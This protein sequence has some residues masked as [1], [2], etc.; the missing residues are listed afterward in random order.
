ME[1][2]LPDH[3]LEI[4]A[5]CTDEARARLRVT[6]RTF[7]R[8][9]PRFAPLAAWTRAHGPD[10]Q[11]T[12]L[13]DGLAPWSHM[14]S[15]PDEID[16]V[17]F[18]TI[19]FRS[20]EPPLDDPYAHACIVRRKVDGIPCHLGYCAEYNHYGRVNFPFV[21]VNIVGEFKRPITVLDRV[22]MTIFF[23]VYMM[24]RLQ[25]TTT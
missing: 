14:T 4:R 2:L 6:C 9:D 18:P 5:R 23:E 19:H 12:L 17:S 22:M 15:G 3:R 20:R 8:E 24:K 10:F 25:Y 7:Y 11:R 16:G 13:A 1:D 21:L